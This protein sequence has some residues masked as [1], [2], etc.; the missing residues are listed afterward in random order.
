[1]SRVI[2]LTNASDCSLNNPYF[3]VQTVV[4]T[5]YLYE[6][7]EE[8]VLSEFGIHPKLGKGYTFSFQDFPQLADLFNVVGVGGNI[9]LTFTE[10]LVILDII[11]SSVTRAYSGGLYSYGDAISVADLFLA[12]K[13]R[14]Q[15]QTLIDVLSLNEIINVTKT[16]GTTIV[17]LEQLSVADLFVYRAVSNGSLNF[18]EGLVAAETFNAFRT[19]GYNLTFLDGILTNDTFLQSV[20]KHRTTNFEER[21]DLSDLFSVQS[22]IGWTFSFSDAINAVETYSLIGRATG[23]MLSYME[24]LMIVEQFSNQVTKGNSV[25]YNDLVAVSEVYGSYIQ[26]YLGSACNIYVDRVEA[27]GGEVI[28]VNAVCQALTSFSSISTSGYQYSYN[29]SLSLSDVFNLVGVA[30]QRNAS[31]IDSV[32]VDDSVTETPAYKNKLY[33][34]DNLTVT[35]L[36][37]LYRQTNVLLSVYD[38]V[39]LIDSQDRQITFAGKYNLSMLDIVP[40]S[41]LLTSTKTNGNTIN[42]LDGVGLQELANIWKSSNLTYS[43]MDSVGAVESFVTTGKSS[44][45]ITFLDFVATLDQVGLART[46]TK[47][48]IFNDSITPG[49]EEAEYVQRYE[50]SACDTY[51]DRVEADGGEVID[52]LGVCQAFTYFSPTPNKGYKLAFSESLNI[53][54]F[55]AVVS[56]VRKTYTIAFVDSVFTDEEFDERRSRNIFLNFT[57]Q[58]DLSASN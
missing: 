17:G 31:F 45:N 58:L 4:P 15:G 34:Q 36:F 21:V 9:T 1:M 51:V 27:D 28:D 56:G 12:N 8:L 6:Y 24:M 41:D 57:E 33:L 32:L 43:F 44:K 23:S 30:K 29:E 54:T 20:L 40:V 26:R 14:G 18:L 5:R 55:E 46:A 16:V 2:N 3:R 19:N 47:N 7:L 25:T 48:L 38:F 10:N 13:G 39:T 52:V 37:N 53:M 50:G 22:G 11:A 49:D 35:D 42:F